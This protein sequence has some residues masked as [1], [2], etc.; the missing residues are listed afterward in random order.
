MRFKRI[1]TDQDPMFLPAIELYK[2]S[3]PLHEQR[4]TLSQRQILENSEYHFDVIYDQDCFVGIILNWETDRSI[5]L[6]HFAI[7]TTIRNKG[8]GARA[9]AY[10]AQRGKRLILE[11]DPPIDAVSIRRKG[12]YERVGFIENPY[13]HIHPP[14]K[15]GN[16][17][18]VLVV[19]TYPTA[20][21][22][23]AYS[24]FATY[25][26]QVVMAR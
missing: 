21:D 5:Y 2:T 14:Y 9:L 8:Y 11:I 24:D 12:F 17:G 22:P 7:D 15:E 26:H 23:T 18:H 20:I 3:F 4:E 1:I 16:E 25:L 6:E 10:L 19:M 13:E